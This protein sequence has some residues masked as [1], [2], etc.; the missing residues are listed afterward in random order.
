MKRIVI[1]LAIISCA[2]L[3][4][5]CRDK[6]DDQQQS[7]EPIVPSVPTDEEEP[8]PDIEPSPTM[9][10]DIPAKGDYEIYWCDEFDYRGLPDDTKWNYDVG[11]H[12]WGNNEIQ[13]YKR[14]DRDNVIVKDDNLIITA[15]KETYQNRHY[16]STRL[17]SKGKFDF[18]YGYIEFR[19]KLPDVGGTW[20]ALWMLGDIDKYGW[21]ECG[22][23]DVMEHVANDLN[24]VHGSIHTTDYNHTN[25]TQKTAK[26]IL[27]D[28]TEYHTYAV[29][30]TPKQVRFFIDDINYFT[31]NNDEINNP[32]NLHSSWPFDDGMFIIMNIAVGGWG[33][34]PD[35]KFTE[36][37]MYVDYV[38]VYQK[39]FPEIEE[40]DITPSSIENLSAKTEKHRTTLT[41]DAAKDNLGVKYYEIYASKVGDTGEPV[42]VG[43]SNIPTYTVSGLEQNS[44]YDITVYAVDFNANIG[45]GATIQITTG[46]YPTIPTRIEAEDYL[47]M[48]GIDVEPTSDEGG[49]VNVG[50]MDQGDHLVYYINVEESG[51]YTI[52]Y[53]VSVNQSGAGYAIYLN[54]DDEPLVTTTFSSTGG[55]QNWRTVESDAFFLE[56]GTHKITL[57]IT[58]SGSNLN[59]LEF[60]LNQ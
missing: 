2:F 12:G 40:D 17:L 59:W 36:A 55:W 9:C 31:F 7:S 11:G 30:W 27:D 41:W 4:T 49:G 21:P 8:L 34:T 57:K 23:I 50:W 19:A 42:L 3:L 46:A 10:D 20:P 33:G 29:E 22:E 24:V 45:E 1:I 26:I 14:A 51:Y 39:D 38:R 60:K 47:D 28:V 54:D 48:S 15:R 52:D 44:K 37:K 16:T 25:N 18:K 58:A 32:N 35:P 5:A 13:Y 53:R 56:K 6:E 43:T